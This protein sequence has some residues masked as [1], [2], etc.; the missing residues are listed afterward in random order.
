MGTSRSDSLFKKPRPAVLALVV[1]LCS[2]L[3]FV[4][5]EPVHASSDSEQDALLADVA[6]GPCGIKFFGNF[7]GRKVLEDGSVLLSRFKTSEDPGP[8]VGADNKIFTRA[9][10]M[11]PG[12]IEQVQIQAH[13][14]ELLDAE[15]TELSQLCGSADGPLASGKKKID[16][17]RMR[18]VIA[19][20]SKTVPDFAV[21]S[22]AFP[23]LKPPVLTSEEQLAIE[24]ING[25]AVA[26]AALKKMA[27][28]VNENMK[29]AISALNKERGYD[30]PFGEAL[31]K[32]V[33]GN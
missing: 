30:I 29:R 9:L 21:F 17:Y 7:T 3:L 16:Q 31:R 24:R 22:S 13:A 4:C 28:K 1:A 6:K 11:A 32:P 12:E 33:S 18:N 25:S 23:P 2:S 8:R 5:S 27:V 20:I 15:L 10:V 19:E 14:G 26:Q